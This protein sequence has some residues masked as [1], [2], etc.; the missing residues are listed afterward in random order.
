LY[1]AAR[2]SPACYYAT[3][4]YLRQRREL[5]YNITRAAGRPRRD[6]PPRAELAQGARVMARLLAA[7]ATAA[8]ALMVLAAADGAAAAGWHGEPAFLASLFDNLASWWDGLPLPGKALVILGLAAGL[9]LLG[10]TWIIP[11]IA[12]GDALGYAF[13]ASAV[14][15]SGHGTAS[16]I[17]D[18]R[19]VIQDY[20]ATRTPTQVAADIALRLLGRGIGRRAVRDAREAAGARHVSAAGWGDPGTLADHFDRHGADF[21]STSAED[22]SRQAS[23]FLERGVRDQLPAKVDPRTGVIR[24]YEPSTN[25]FGAYNANGTTRTFYKPDV[26][27]HGYRTNWDYWQDQRG[28]TPWGS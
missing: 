2:T 5:G 4:R 3:A 12:F 21:G 1:A 13:D 10:G 17:R 18:P 26:S 15:A 11:E 24:I 8:V 27:V 28:S 16:F 14:A 25:T 7:G 6:A 19:Q 22:Y 9:T 23:E 20:L